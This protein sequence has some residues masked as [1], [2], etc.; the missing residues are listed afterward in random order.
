MAIQ[1]KESQLKR[2]HILIIFNPTAGQRRQ[3]LLSQVVRQLLTKQWDVTLQPTHYAGDGATLAAN[4]VYSHLYTVVCAAGG[5][6]TINEVLSGLIQAE[7]YSQ[8]FG[9]I[10]LGTANVLANELGYDKKTLHWANT[11]TSN[12][13]KQVYI[14]Q[15]TTQTDRRHF[16]CMAGVGFDASVVSSVDKQLK[17]VIGKG[18]YIYRSIQLLWQ[19]SNKS[20]DIKIDGQTQP[21]ATAMI[22]C[23]GHFYGGRFVLAPQAKLTDKTLQFVLFSGRGSW[24]V[25]RLIISMALGHT[26]KMKDLK[27]V[28]GQKLEISDNTGEPIQADGDDVGQLPATF[29]LFEKTMTIIYPPENRIQS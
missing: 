15:L 13:T 29:T 18:A 22:A 28:E 7:G 9:I 27:V 5:D 12:N 20:Y 6:G 17:K 23:N 24:A 25:I 21:L 1:N 10:P 14:G 3:H 19:F 26:H 2:P 4:A 11:L 8:P 16:I